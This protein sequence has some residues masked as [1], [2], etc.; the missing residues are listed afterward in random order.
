MSE[1]Q[2]VSVRDWMRHGGRLQMRITDANDPDDVI[3]T[4]PDQKVFLTNLA[5]PHSFLKNE[6]CWNIKMLFLYLSVDLLQVL[7]LNCMYSDDFKIREANQKPIQ[8]YILDIVSQKRHWFPPE[9]PFCLSLKNPLYIANF[10]IKKRF[11]LL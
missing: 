11:I 8:S 1:Y 4:R 6:I 10:I 7:W 5:N 3:E 2:N 9:S